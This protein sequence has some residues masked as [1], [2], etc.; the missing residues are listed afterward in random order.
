MTH[1]AVMMSGK[2]AGYKQPMNYD[3]EFVSDCKAKGA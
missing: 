3:F 1:E 2:P